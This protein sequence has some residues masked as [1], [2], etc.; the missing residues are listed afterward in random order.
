MKKS[1]I[2][3]FLLMI[4]TVSLHAQS[5]QPLSD[6]TASDPKTLGI[7]QGFPPPPDKLVRLADGSLWKFPQLRWSFSHMTEL[8]P[9]VTV[10][11]GGNRATE[12]PRAEHGNLDQ[13]AFETL[14]GKR[15]TWGQSLTANYTDGIV[16]MQR[17]RIVYEKYFGALDERTPHII[18][19]CTKSFVGTLAAIL[20]LEGKLD[21]SA[22]TF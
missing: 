15:M 13:V 1:F 7:M 16:V 21:P 2:A 19:S 11:R 14:D 9:A 18:M 20:A 8:G 10:W 22:T 12:I 4:S 17:G 3:I 5:S 6:A